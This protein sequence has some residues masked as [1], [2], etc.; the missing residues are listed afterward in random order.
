MARM[1]YNKEGRLVPVPENL[2]QGSA[3]ARKYYFPLGERIPMLDPNGKLTEVTPEQFYQVAA[4]D[5]WLY[6]TEDH[7]AK[8]EMDR[9]FGG[10][11][12]G[13][14]AAG[15][16][17]LSSMGAGLPMTL[18]SDE[19]KELIKHRPGSFQAGE[20]G[21][22]FLPMGAY[23][24]G[25]KGAIAATKGLIQ[26]TAG[27]SAT[28]RMM[29]NIGQGGAVGAV[30]GTIAG[31]QTAITENELSDD[32]KK[33]AEVMM[34]TAPLQGAGI[35]FGIGGGLGFVG[36]LAKGAI[37]KMGVGAAPDRVRKRHEEAMDFSE[38][39]LKGM[40]QKKIDR[41]MDVIERRGLVT[42]GQKQGVGPLMKAEEIFQGEVKPAYLEFLER[43]R[44]VEGEVFAE[45]P[46]I[47]F[48]IE[49]IQDDILEMLSELE[50]KPT[51]GSQKLQEQLMEWSA[52]FENTIVNKYGK[53]ISFSDARDLRAALDEFDIQNFGPEK[54]TTLNRYLKNIRANW[55]DEVTESLKRALENEKIAAELG[56]DGVARY[57]TLKEDYEA[58]STLHKAAVD[59]AYKEQ[60]K[61]PFGGIPDMAF[62]ASFG[63]AQMGGTMGSRALAAKYALGG[64][65]G[66]KIVRTY[67]TPM[68]AHASRGLQKGK[69]L[70]DTY[71][72]KVTR[73]IV[74]ILK[75]DSSK[76]RRTLVFLATRG[77][78]KGEMD[79]E[80]MKDYFAEIDMQANDAQ[81]MRLTM[82]QK[83][84][85]MVEDYPNT[86][87]AM[88]EQYARAIHFL[89]QKIPRD[90][91]LNKQVEA[92][93]YTPGD[94]ERRRFNR[95]LAVAENP[96]SVLDQ[97]R[98][99]T[100]S[101]EG[102]E[103]LKVLYP[104]IYEDIQ[105]KLMQAIAENKDQIPYYR[106]QMISQLFELPYT[107]SMYGGHIKTVQD[108]YK[109][110]KAKGPQNKRGSV[111]AERYQTDIQRVQQ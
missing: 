97:I 30:E 4:Q 76:R 33:L 2:V 47:F 71:D 53:Y 57:K 105:L 94:N 100:L 45:S 95:Y 18:Y 14:K 11:G 32:P 44:N 66:G 8:L 29:A 88:M 26:A 34:S 48:N 85:E 20:L 104:L 1:M 109:S 78:T 72:N 9:K 83:F 110:V 80:E 16:G 89:Q 69:V 6:A 74:D 54:H 65:F 99:N 40:P 102:V 96:L 46:E 19:N 10:F 41:I 93:E 36:F 86:T 15:L 64:L 50:A 37:S 77:A 75:P 31:A 107:P 84:E 59:R 73:A 67:G 22:A 62:G 101:K 63:M 51:P 61:N 17:A 56:S 98:N 92:E 90:S 3:L 5:G 55:D 81:T 28:K 25:A 58:F 12:M 39:F 108:I 111:D 24:L 103:T 49:R 87:P 106:K 52:A 43:I 42:M 79:S 82:A 38:S 60:T 91:L 27:K 68:A 21:G 23:G 70:W 35:G 7:R 13:L